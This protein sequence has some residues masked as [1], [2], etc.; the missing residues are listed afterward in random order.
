MVMSAEEEEEKRKI[1]TAD[2]LLVTFQNTEFFHCPDIE[3]PDSLIA[4]GTCNEVT[5]W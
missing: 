4:R 3:H 1:H 2:F 5:V